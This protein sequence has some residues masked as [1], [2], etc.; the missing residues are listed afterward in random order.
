[1]SR[2]PPERTDEAVDKD[3]GCV[4]FARTVNFSSEMLFFSKIS[5]V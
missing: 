3:L 4:F 2:D 1:M 5:G